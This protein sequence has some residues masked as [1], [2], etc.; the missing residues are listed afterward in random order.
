MPE[1]Q[2][3][4]GRRVGAE[5]TAASERTVAQTLG[6]GQPAA[7]A[8]DEEAGGA[9]RV[10]KQAAEDDR[11]ETTARTRRRRQHRVTDVGRAA[12]PRPSYQRYTVATEYVV[13]TPPPE[14]STWGEVTSQNLRS[15]FHRHFVGIIRYNV[16]S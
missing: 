15:R 8:G 13:I 1:L 11:R 2:L 7:D 9:D 14:G 4:C 12:G 3:Q 5:A 16:L 6:E 10:D